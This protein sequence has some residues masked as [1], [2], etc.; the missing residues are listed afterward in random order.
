MGNNLR[1]PYGQEPLLLKASKVFGDWLNGGEPMAF[2]QVLDMIQVEVPSSK[3]VLWMVFPIRETWIRKSTSFSCYNTTQNFGYI[4][5]FESPSTCLVIKVFHP[6]C[7]QWNPSDLYPTP[8]EISH[9]HD[10][11]LLLHSRHVWKIAMHT[12][13]WKLVCIY[14]K[15]ACTMDC[16]GTLF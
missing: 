2:Q 9:H 12:F 15:I 7:S 6:T 3:I 11:M 8:H 14:I 4:Q 13:E 10:Q 16:P 5:N 1:I